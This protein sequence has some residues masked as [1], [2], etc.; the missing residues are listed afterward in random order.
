MSDRNTNRSHYSEPTAISRL[1][2]VAAGEVLFSAS[3]HICTRKHEGI[4]LARGACK[5]GHVQAFSR[6]FQTSFQSANLSTWKIG[7]NACKRPRAA[8]IGCKRS[9]AFSRFLS[10]LL[11]REGIVS[12]ACV[13][14][15]RPCARSGASRAIESWLAPAGDLDLARRQRSSSDADAR[16]SESPARGHQRPR[17]MPC[18]YSFGPP[19]R[20]CGRPR[21]GPHPSRETPTDPRGTKD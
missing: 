20:W 16:A 2:D 6:L 14:R 1:F 13:L 3:V 18:R 10:R 15:G 17:T 11:W 8:S 4:V 19:R 5:S 9:R 7:E 21:A 12:R